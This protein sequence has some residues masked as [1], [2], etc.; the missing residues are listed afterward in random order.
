MINNNPEL[1]IQNG[2]SVSEQEAKAVVL[3]VALILTFLPVSVLSNQSY[4][5]HCPSFMCPHVDT[6]FCC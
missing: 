2:G 1:K 6:V 3:D 5:Q 4:T